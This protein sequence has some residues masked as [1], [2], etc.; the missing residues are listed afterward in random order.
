MR[1]HHMVVELMFSFY[2]FA[3]DLSFATGLPC[4]GV[5]PWSC[6]TVTSHL[7]REYGATYACALLFIVSYDDSN[8]VLY[9]S[10]DSND[11]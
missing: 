9:R 8:D 2:G 11:G 6:R 10:C 5:A 1:S 7:L 4:F 3:F